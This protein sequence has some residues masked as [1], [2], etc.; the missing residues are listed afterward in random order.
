LSFTGPTF[1]L[2]AGPLQAT[3]EGR[4]A[5][6]R[7]RSHSTFSIAGGDARFHRSEQSLRGAIEIPLTSRDN[8]LLPELGELTGTAEYARVHFSDAGTVN[9]HSLGLTWEPRPLIRLR[10]AIE[11]TE[12]PAAIQTLGSPVIVSPLVRIFDPLT[13]ETVDVVQVT[14]GNPDL[15]PE[16]TTVRRLSGILRPL[17]RLQLSAEYTDTDSR[18]FVSSLPEASAAVML[19][20]PE[21]FVRD[22]S[23]ILTTVDLRP[24]NF[25]SHREK[26]LRYGFSLNTTLGEKPA[27]GPRRSGPQTRLQLTANHTMVFSDRILIRPGLDS[28]DLLEGG[29]IGIAS[30]RV[31]HQ[32]DGTAALTSGGL[33]ARLGVTW[34]GPSTLESRIGTITDTLRFSPLF[35][36]NLRAF[37]DMRRLL[38]HRDWA[39]GLRLSVEVVNLTNDRQEVRDSAGDTPLR[40]QPGY[41]DPLGR[42]IELAIRKVF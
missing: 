23:R 28:V 25:D 32:L 10:A 39:K 27:A 21:R 9:S 20:F 30:G 17:P 38:P 15:A 18:N 3:V 36:V 4:L 37:A 6:N 42:T 2:P 16:K 40:Y 13:G 31:R 19:A 29:A 24:V 41:R 34:R 5:W 12:R 33:G 1:S 11:Q 7:L 22:S 14:G 35:L 8:G 26:R